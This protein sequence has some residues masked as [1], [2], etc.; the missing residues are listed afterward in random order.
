MAEN[1]KQKNGKVKT[2][3]KDLCAKKKK[4]DLIVS[5]AT[6]GWER[7]KQAQPMWK[8]RFELASFML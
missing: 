6:L 1:Y 7:A 2:S 8:E 3:A 4:E 5:D